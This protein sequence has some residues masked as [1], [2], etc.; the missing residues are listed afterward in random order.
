MGPGSATWARNMEDI[1][2][3]G[4][5]QRS[6]PA[7]RP[8]MPPSLSPSTGVHRTPAVCQP[9]SQALGLNK[10]SLAPTFVDPQCQQVGFRNT[11]NKLLLPSSNH[12][13]SVGAPERRKGR[14]FLG[15]GV[16]RE[17]LSR[18]FC[19]GL[20]FQLATLQYNY[21][22]NILCFEIHTCELSGEV[23]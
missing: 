4:R 17:F 3:V 13:Y 18:V 23:S 15:G 7:L 1:R 20:E 11:Y 14:A 8:K 12:N 19:G 22:P 9:W 5:A 2:R 6:G 21:F 10:T 16:G